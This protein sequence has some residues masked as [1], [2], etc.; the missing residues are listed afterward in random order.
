MLG[1][2]RSVVRRETD[3]RLDRAGGWDRRD[4]AAMRGGVVDGVVGI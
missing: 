3:L 2:I 1:A 4:D